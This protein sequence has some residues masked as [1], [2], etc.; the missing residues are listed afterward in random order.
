MQEFKSWLEYLR[1]EHAVKR[2]S[3]YV[4]EAEG[5]DFLKAVLAS[6]GKRVETLPAGGFVWRAQLGH[7][8]EPV[9]Q[10]GE[11][12]DNRPIPYPPDRMKPL[13]DRAKEGRAN[14][15]GIPCLYV[16]TSRDT[17]LAE[18][19]PWI[20]SLISVA[21]FR[22]R[23]ELRVVNCTTHGKASYVYVGAE[24]SPE[25]RE[26]AVWSDVDRAFAKPATP[27]DDVAD[28]APTQIIAELFKVHGFDGI[29]YE[30]SLGPGHNIAL[31]DLDAADLVNRSL[32]RVK[33]VKFDFTTS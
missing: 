31:F 6:A 10:D 3:R 30:S 24:P 26:E 13:R 22:I 25:A 20:G 7:D 2:R 8:M 9:F 19:R 1:F 16:A 5:D 28:Y 15:R 4:R 14:P 17:A 23:R 11:H 18:V 27:G 12:I 33:D 32:F 21:Q 29:A